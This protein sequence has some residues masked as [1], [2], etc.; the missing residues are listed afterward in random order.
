MQGGAGERKGTNLD[1]QQEKIDFIQRGVL[2][3]FHVMRSGVLNCSPIRGNEH[4]MG[5][6]Y[7]H[8]EYRE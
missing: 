3:I 7:S 2:A 8:G 5:R 4:E 6:K 1:G